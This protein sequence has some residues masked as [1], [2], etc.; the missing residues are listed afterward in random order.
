MTRLALGTVQ[1][2]LNYGVANYSGQTNLSEVKKIIK[3]ARKASVD[4]VD[5][6]ISYGNS[7]KIIGEVGIT[8]FRF[9]T[10]LPPI[11]N[12]NKDI[13]SWVEKMVKDSL[14]RLGVKSIYGLLIH[15]YKDLLGDNGKK[16]VYALDQIKTSGLVKKIGISIYD[17]SE[18]GQVID[19][20]KIDIIQAPLNIIDRRL[21]ISGWLKK[22]NKK[23]IEV[24]TR[25]TFLQGLLLMEQTKIPLKFKRWKNIFDFWFKELKKD[26]LN[27]THACLSYPMSLPEIDRIIVGVDTAGQFENLIKLSKS[28]ILSKDLSF[29]ISDDKL[30]I[31]PY[32]WGNL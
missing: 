13:T 15:R 18:I 22:L 28:K 5:T 11:L 32:N 26:N 19:L 10:K 27:A 14:E 12:N 17:P 16:L 8:D 20:L 25:S 3:L 1:F 30:L 4:L 6:A 31:N 2:G 23:N 24:H 21:E 7:E 29:M 9:V